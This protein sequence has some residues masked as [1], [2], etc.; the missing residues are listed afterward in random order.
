MSGVSNFN[1][2]TLFWPINI[3]AMGEINSESKRLFTSKKQRSLK[4][5]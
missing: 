3:D 5:C 2:S 1:R 4:Y